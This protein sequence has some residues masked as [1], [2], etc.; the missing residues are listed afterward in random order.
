[1]YYPVFDPATPEDGR[2]MTRYAFDFSE[3]T[4][5]PVIIRPTTR[6][7]HSSGIVT[8]GALPENRNPIEFTKNPAR[9]VPIPSNARR[10]RKE[11]T[12]RYAEAARLLEETEFF[13]RTGDGTKGIL[14]SGVAYA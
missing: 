9:Y 5:L 11:L 14:A 4:R 3:Q 2:K 13:P 10:M 8:F 1:L 7:C 6:V 12:E